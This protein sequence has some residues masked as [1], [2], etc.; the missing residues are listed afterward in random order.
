MGTSGIFFQGWA[1]GDLKDGSPPTRSR[2][3]AAVGIW[4]LTTFSQNNA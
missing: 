2:G 3:I 4:G 1:L